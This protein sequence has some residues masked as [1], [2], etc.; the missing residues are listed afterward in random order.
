ML[1]SN[2]PLVDFYRSCLESARRKNYILAGCL[3]AREADSK[4]LYSTLFESWTSLHDLTGKE[5]CLLFAGYT[6][7]SDRDFID[8]FIA[9]GKNEKNHDLSFIKA[10]YLPFPYFA[11]LSATK[12]GSAYSDSTIRRNHTLEISSLKEF[13]GLTEMKLPCFVIT[14]LNNE[15]NYVIPVNNTNFYE[16]MKFLIVSLEDEFYQYNMSK[17]K[18]AANQRN[19]DLNYAISTNVNNNVKLEESILRIENI[20]KNLSQKRTAEIV[21]EHQKRFRVA[22]SFAGEYRIYVEQV[23]KKLAI[24]GFKKDELLYDMYHEADF[25][26]P[27]LDV[28]LYKLYSSEAELIVVFLSKEYN[29]KSWTGLEYRAIRRIINERTNDN[30]IMLVRFDKSEIDGLSHTTDG[31]IDVTRHNPESLAELIIQRYRQLEHK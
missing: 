8:V 7:Y 13:F 30:S 4:E 22:V 18:F 27:N 20:V 14:V 9:D 17:E 26:R 11:T 2:I 10:P 5:M 15:H 25:S 3:I 19:G 24:S 6:G 16:F 23:M 1:V 28:Y 29:T 31:S 21:S 12:D